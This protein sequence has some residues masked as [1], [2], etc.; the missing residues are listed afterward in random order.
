MNHLND[1]TIRQYAAGIVECRICGLKFLPDLQEDRELHEQKHWQIICGGLPYE[2]R[3]FIK[4]AAWDTL[5]NKR[6]PENQ[7]EIA[8][9]A[10]VFAWWARAMSNGIPENHFEPFMAAHLAYI[11]ASVSGDEDQI[12]EAE[13][14]IARWYQYG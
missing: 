11:D 14:I 2:I 9:R 12:D 5:R 8:K 1:L 4:R 13:Q 7:Q 3:E 6:G 10:I